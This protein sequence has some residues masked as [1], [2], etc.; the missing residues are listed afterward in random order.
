MLPETVIHKWAETEPNVKIK[1]S[2]MS[3]GYQWE[4]TYEGQDGRG[5]IN[6]IKSVDSALK[7]C[8]KEE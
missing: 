5:V 3:K 6:V 4:I 1:L 8:F 2:K 7:E